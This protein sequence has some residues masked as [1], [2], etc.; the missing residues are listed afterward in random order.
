MALPKQRVAIVNGPSELEWFLSRELRAKL[1]GGTQTFAFNETSGETF[2]ID[3]SD[4]GGGTWTYFQR[5]FT[6]TTTGSGFANIAALLGEINT[7]AKWN[8]GTLPT[9]FTVS[10]EG[11]KLVLKSAETGNSI[12]LRVNAASTAIGATPNTD[13]MFTGGV[14]TTGGNGGSQDLD[15]LIDIFPD[16]NGKYIVVYAVP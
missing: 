5:T 10:N 16:N 2:I 11:D 9:E 6:F 1:V 12:G 8:G 4:D 15:T 14:N 3:G 13:L 7:A